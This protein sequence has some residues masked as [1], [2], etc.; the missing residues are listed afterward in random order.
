MPLYTAIIQEGSLS[1]ETKARISKEITR[2]HTA[3]MKVPRIS[4]EWSSSFIPGVRDI[5]RAMMPRPR[6]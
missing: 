6:R 3:I 5:R 2:I 1:D 4:F